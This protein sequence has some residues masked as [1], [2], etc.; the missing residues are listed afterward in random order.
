MPSLFH[1]QTEVRG[2]RR[3]RGAIQQEVW[4]NL[5]LPEDR[6][7]RSCRQ[8]RGAGQE[9]RLTTQA[10]HRQNDASHPMSPRQTSDGGIDFLT[11]L[12]NSRGRKPRISARD[13]SSASALGYNEEPGEEMDLNMRVVI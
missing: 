4:R 8:Y 5:Q 11:P 9:I 7:A 12:L 3:T 6:R 2:Y 1:G 13:E 10:F